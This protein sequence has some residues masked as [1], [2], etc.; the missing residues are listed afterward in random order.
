MKGSAQE[1]LWAYLLVDVKD[2]LEVERSVSQLD[3]TTAARTEIR[4][5]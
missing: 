5:V 4:V 2:D 3:N 1:L